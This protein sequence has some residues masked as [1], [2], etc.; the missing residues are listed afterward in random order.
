MNNNKL[1]YL[2]LHCTATPE[3]RPVTKD[4]IIRWHTN[5]VHLG[6]RGW[7]RPGYSDLVELDGD[8]VSIIPFNTDDF[9]DQWEIS[10]G[11]VGL[12]GNA[13]HIVYAGGMD[14]ENKKPKDTRTKEQLATLEVYVKYTI[15]RHPKILVL[16]HNEAPNAHGKACPSFNV[17]EWLRSI[18]VAEAN[19]YHKPAVEENKTTVAEATVETNSTE[20]E[21]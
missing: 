16:G 9:V 5:P 19:I 1:N 3:G 21:A 13:R 2:V 8:L 18:G 12:N 10:N 17:G 11:V 7:N 4:E 20:A 15:K 14:T 6:G